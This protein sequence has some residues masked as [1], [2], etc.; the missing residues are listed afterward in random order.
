MRSASPVAT[1]LVSTMLRGLGLAALLL[2]LAGCSGTRVVY[3]QLDWL[4]VWQVKK[5][6]ELD[7]SQEQ[8]L[9]ERVARQ[10]A[11]HRETQL[12]RYAA[13]SEDLA[14]V[15]AGE[16]DP[17]YFAARFAES[18]VFWADF[19]SHAVPDAAAFLAGLSDAQVE[20]LFENIEENNRELAEE[21]SGDTAAI[22]AARREQAIVR[23]V[24]RLT[25]RL[26]GAQKALVRDYSDRMHD[27]S[28]AWLSRRRAWQEELRAA[29]ALRDNGMELERRL[30][31]LLV[32]P[33]RNDPPD[34]RALVEENQQ[35]VFEMLAALA[36]ELTPRQRERFQKR[37]LDFARDFR[38]LAGTTA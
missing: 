37:L 17:E 25:G 2:A 9:R 21:Y 30:A 24:S 27:L 19:M 5:Y 15:L 6:F 22:R 8:D 4:V 29:L 31:P 28:Q 36:V 34:Y 13:L 14:Q 38:L 32:D 35:I 20:Q 18:Q 23:S 7:D 26:N 10:L 16:P 3:N 11:W 1:H 12:P 33:D